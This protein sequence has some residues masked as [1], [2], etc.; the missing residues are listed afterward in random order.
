MNYSNQ[1]GSNYPT[2]LIDVGTKKDIDDT[3]V[4][5]VNQYYQFMSSG[6]VDAAA[7]LYNENK[8]LLESYMINM[9]YFNRLEEEIYNVALLALQK[10]NIIVSKY[11][12]T[13]QQKNSVW[14]RDK[15]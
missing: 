15:E 10:T 1:F 6:N 13:Y 4:S 8:D 5:L 7:T 9:E 2:S 3:I 11:E 14:Y 12:P